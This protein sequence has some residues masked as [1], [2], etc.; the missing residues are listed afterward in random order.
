MNYVQ[1]STFILNLAKSKNLLI[2]G[3]LLMRMLK[4]SPFIILRICS[5][6]WKL[7]SR[8]FVHTFQHN[9]D[10]SISLIKSKLLNYGLTGYIPTLVMHIISQNNTLSYSRQW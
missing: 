7:T 5:N 2:Y 10:S 1:V 9:E 6:T 3:M 4:P 8:H